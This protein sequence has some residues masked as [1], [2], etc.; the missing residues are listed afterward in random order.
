MTLTA[1]AP[2]P[3]MPGMPPSPSG[4]G[5]ESSTAPPAGAAEATAPDTSHASTKPRKQTSLAHVLEVLHVLLHRAYGISE[6]LWR[7]GPKVLAPP[8]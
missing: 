5:G 8:L 1:R 3:M 4:G 7:L 6:R 2:A